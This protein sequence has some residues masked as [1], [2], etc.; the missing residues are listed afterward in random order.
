MCGI[1]GYISLKHIKK[2]QLIEMADSMKHRGPDF[3]GIEQFYLDEYKIGLAHTRLSI[4]D[5]SDFGRQPMWSANHEY[6]ITFNGEIYNFLELRKNLEQ[7]GYKFIS[8]SDTEVILAGYNKWGRDCV[9]HFCGMFAFVI[10]DLK[11]HE[12]FAARDRFG[13]KPFYYYKKGKEFV[14]A[15]ELKPI[16]L[17]PGFDQKIN[18]YVLGRYMRFGNISSPDTIF[19]NTFKLPPGSYMIIK[20]NEINIECYW[21]ATEKGRELSEATIGSFDKAKSLLDQELTLSV[22]RRMIS[23]VPVGLFLS[24]GIDSSLVAAIAQKVAGKPIKSFTIGVD[25]KTLN[26]ATFAK[27]IANHLGTDHHEIY[28]NEKMM[29]DLVDSIP[30][31]YDEPFSDSSQVAEMLV[32]QI[33]KKEITVALSGD[34]G[35][36]LFCGYPNYDFVK[37]AQQYETVAKVMRPFLLSQALQKKISHK[38]KRVLQ[39]TNPNTK[40]QL[41]MKEDIEFLDSILLNPYKEPYFEVESSMKIKD[42]QYRRMLLDIKTSLP[43][44]MLHKVDRASMKYSL[45]VRCP[46]LDHN[47]AELSFRMPQQFKYFKGEK[48][49]IL[50]QLTYDYVPKSML[51]GPKRGFSVPIQLWLQTSLRNRLEA[52]STEQYLKTQGIF[53]FKGISSL[54]NEFKKNATN[55][56][57]TYC[58]NFLIF[59]MWYAEYIGNSK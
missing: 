50:K 40:S 6:A 42:W 11:N 45:E 19:E 33:A 32:S 9:R 14:F 24:S 56:L 48:K 55:Q 3:L 37:K 53:R 29:L 52:Y 41:V 38:V 18:D 15:S 43:D 31:Y 46:L 28:V 2:E 27:K 39:N 13:K 23:D 22:K 30:K 16:M 7:Y 21:D 47:V 35:D 1:C 8:N 20:N 4:I 44:D 54:K 49:Y 17:Y 25:D 36:E 10:V 59:Q 26:E 34:G 57:S 5:L 58:W 12:T 51:D